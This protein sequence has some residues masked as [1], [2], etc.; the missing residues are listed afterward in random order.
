[1]ADGNFL[2]ALGIDT[3]LV[4]AGAAGGLVKA[5]IGK[6]KVVDGMASMIVGAMVANYA[7]GPMAAMLSAVE[8]FGTRLSLRP[9]VG[10]FFV[11]IFAFALVAGVG[12]KLRERFGDG[13]AK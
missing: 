1:M 2:A 10:G 12:A 4:T 8:V 6:Q 3:Q 11:G 5:L 9:E 7:G 13:A